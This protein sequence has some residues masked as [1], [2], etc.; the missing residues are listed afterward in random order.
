MTPKGQVDPLQGT[1]HAWEPGGPAVGPIVR[2]WEDRLCI[3]MLIQKWI[4]DL[5]IRAKTII[6]LEENIGINLCCLRLGSV[7]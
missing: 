5:N 2:V 3:Q 1:C 4:M 7:S 6:L